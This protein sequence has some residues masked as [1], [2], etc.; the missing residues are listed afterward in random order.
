MILITCRECIEN[1]KPSDPR[2]KAGRY[3]MRGCD[4]CPKEPYYRELENQESKPQEIIHRYSDMSMKDYDLL[5]QTA[6][7]VDYLEKRLNVKIRKSNR[8]KE[9]F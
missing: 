2:V 4:Y 5:T 9:P 6:L 3:K 1:L 8:Q 7:K